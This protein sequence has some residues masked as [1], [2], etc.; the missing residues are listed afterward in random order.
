MQKNKHTNFFRE[1]EHGYHNDKPLY[2]SVAIIVAVAL[3]I[4]LAIVINS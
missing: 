3:I 1:I 4:G 2:I